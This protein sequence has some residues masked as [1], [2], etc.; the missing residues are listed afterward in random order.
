MASSHD[1]HDFQELTGLGRSAVENLFRQ[2]YAP[3]HTPDFHDAITKAQAAGLMTEKNAKTA[4]MVYLTGINKDRAVELLDSDDIEYDLCRAINKGRMWDD[5]TQHT[6][7]TAQ[8]RVL[9]TTSLEQAKHFLEQARPQ[10]YLESAVDK[11]LET[12]A[13]SSKTAEFAIF[14]LLTAFSDKTAAS[15]LAQ[16]GD[17]AQAMVNGKKNFLSRND[18]TLA[19]LRYRFKLKTEDARR[20]LQ[21]P[22]VQG[23]YELAL[24]QILVD[25][26]MDQVI[27]DRKDAYQ[28]LNSVNGNVDKAVQLAKANHL[29]KPG[30]GGISAD[31]RNPPDVTGKT[32]IIGVL[33]VSDLGH[34]RRASPRVDGW[35]VSDFYLWMSILEGMGKSQSWHTCENP[36]ALIEK[37]GQE[38]ME[39]D[40]T[41]DQ[42]ELKR[43]SISWREGYLHGDPFEDRVL[44]LSKNNVQQMAKR[45]TLSS[46]GTSLRDNFLRRVEETCREAEAANEP[47][48]LMGFCHSDD[49]ETESGGLC[50]GIDPGTQNEDDFLSPKL[51]AQVLAKTPRVRV[52]MYLTSC[53]SGNNLLNSFKT[54]TLTRCFKG[55]WVITPD[56][57]ILNVTTMAAAQEYEESWAWRPSSSMR[58]AGG[59]Y[60]SAFLKELQQEPHELPDD[61]D[62]DESRTYGQVCQ[63]VTAEASRL[64]VQ[65]GGS[66]PMFTKDDGHDKFWKRTGFSLAD[67]QRNYDRLERVPASDPNPYRDSKRR[68]SEVSQSEYE[69][70]KARHPED[71][72]EE[73]S[74]RTGGYGKTR[75]GLGTSLTY[76]ASRYM[77]SLP[78]PRNAPSNTALQSDIELFRAGYHNN[79][80]DTIE[81]IR[82]QILYRI[83]MMQLANK[84]RAYLNLNKVPVIEKWNQENPGPAYQLAKENL[85]LVREAKIFKRPDAKGYWGQAWQKPY[86][87]LAYAFA[88]SEYGPADIPKYLTKVTQMQHNFATYKVREYAQFSTS[89]GSVRHMAEILKRSWGKSQQRQKRTSLEE[90]GMMN[91]EELMAQSPKKRAKP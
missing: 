32:H 73:Y 37:Y 1:V 48:L 29:H 7:V 17:V 87:Y 56:F 89:H 85:R 59:V 23:D 64:W 31:T 86:L 20:Y 54:T 76:L 47:V 41:D 43:S 10:G 61:A 11:A 45:L 72:D 52:S 34:Q 66:T 82:S 24:R 79:D 28:Y 3:N 6:A 42:G 88:A 21:R 57:R 16:S 44:V 81:R 75:R 26:V 18:F 25:I 77:A 51:L 68:V 49:G 83:W 90:A 71:A 30:Y 91:W 8:F 55:N 80:L 9:T 2:Y 15:L 14:K 46:H 53:Y 65:C 58:H 74:T 27:V 39:L 84:I 33:G 12:G 62:E 36:Y 19:R 78:G 69:A 50:I 22:D 38:A 60:T 70:W 35:M 67:Y 40:Y 63:A 5:L 4:S 13:I